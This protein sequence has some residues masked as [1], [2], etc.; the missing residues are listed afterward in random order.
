VTLKAIGRPVS[1]KTEGAG[2][3]LDLQQ[4]DDVASSWERMEGA[5]GP[6]MTGGIV[7]AMVA[8]GTD[9]RVVLEP[10]PIVGA[11]VGVGTGG[12]TAATAGPVARAVLPLSDTSALDL[13]HRSGFD[14]L[15]DDAE[16]AAVVDLLLRVSWLAEEVAD[17]ARV[18]LNP[19]IV[20][21]GTAWVVDATIDVV[22]DHDRPPDDL[23]RLSG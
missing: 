17:I 23:R 12:A 6:A 8:P 1:A 15:L 5:L 11:T 2:V 18:E 21:D 9:L 10:A 3:G 16:V 20:S 19:V 22:E 14:E 7:Q 13:L 4:P